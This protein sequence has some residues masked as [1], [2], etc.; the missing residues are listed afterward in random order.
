MLSAQLLSTI[1]DELAW[2]EPELALA[3]IYLQRSI[4]DARHFSYSYRCFVAMTYAH[5]EAFTKR[6]IAQGIQDIFACGDRW[7]TFV[8]AVKSNLFASGLRAS[9][10]QLSNDELVEKASVTA[11]LLDGVE[12]PSL[13]IILEIGNMNVT[14]F[15]WAI[16]CIGLDQTKFSFARNDIGQLTA[17]RH[18]CAH[19]EMLSFD[20]TKTR[21]EIANEMYS[22]QSRVLTVMH[23]LAVE[24]IDHFSL[25]N[26]KACAPQ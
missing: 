23:T 10:K 15:F 2:R 6:V 25:E 3:K 13:D 9:L 5:F 11:C 17:R 18:D 22:L 7:S 1:D 26:F 24:M 12:A 16:E 19:G 20:R 21:N 8:P 4:G 14:N